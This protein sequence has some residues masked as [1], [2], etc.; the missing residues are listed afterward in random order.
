MRF[1]TDIYQ[2]ENKQTD[3]LYSS[4]IPLFKGLEITDMVRSGECGFH[5]NSSVLSFFPPKTKYLLKHPLKKD[6][7]KL[8]KTHKPKEENRC[9]QFKSNRN[10]SNSYKC[11][12]NT[13]LEHVLAL[14][15]SVN[16]NPWSIEEVHGRKRP[17][18]WNLIT[19]SF[20]GGARSGDQNH[21]ALQRVPV[22][23]TPFLLCPRRARY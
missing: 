15:S 17:H 16:T 7:V 12:L 2:G 18:P 11:G 6:K 5:L 19:I 14:N 1:H 4:I 10:T 21:T 22:T 9:V 3:K 8:S 23:L 13:V 20:C